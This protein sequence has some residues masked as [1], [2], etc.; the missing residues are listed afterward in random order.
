MLLG[1]GSK[2]LLPK[3]TKSKDT[4]GRIL[5]EMGNQRVDHGETLI[6]RDSGKPWSTLIPAF[7]GAGIPWST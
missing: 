3:N 6:T 4:K 2:I 5:R 7:G 1:R